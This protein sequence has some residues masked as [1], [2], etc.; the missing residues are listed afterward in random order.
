MSLHF[1]YLP[2]YCFYDLEENYQKYLAAFK[3]EFDNWFR[4]ILIQVQGNKPE[5][6][7]PESSAVLLYI[8]DTIIINKKV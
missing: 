5:E 3:A 6:T 2:K 8:D 7:P 1:A 4:S